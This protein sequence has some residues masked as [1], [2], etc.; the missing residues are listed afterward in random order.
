MGKV[1]AEKNLRRGAVLPLLFLLQSR[2]QQESLRTG[3]GTKV[4]PHSLVILVWDEAFPVTAAKKVAVAQ[5]SCPS[6][7]ISKALIW[8][9]PGAQSSTTS[10]RTIEDKKQSLHS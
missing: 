4:L 6:T 2:T 5:I 7:E 10:A 9:S 3:S 1:G 8:P